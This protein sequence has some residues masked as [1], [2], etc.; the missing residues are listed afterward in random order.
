MIVCHNCNLVNKNEHRVILQHKSHI[1]H[2][3]N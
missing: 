3:L 2:L 1:S